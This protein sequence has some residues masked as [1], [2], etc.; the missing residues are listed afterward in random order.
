VIPRNSQEPEADEQTTFPVVSLKLSVVIVNWNTA[1]LLRE[2]LKSLHLETFAARGYEAIVVDN[3]SSDGSTAMVEHEFP[4]ARLIRM[5][6]NGG[7]SKGN[8][9]G[10]RQSRG[11]F[12]LLLNSDTEVQGN[13]LELM[14]SR[15]KA[16]PK[17]GALGAQLRNPDGTVQLSCRR[18][19]SYKTALFNRK[20][21]LTRLF[22]RNRFSQAYLMTHE[23]H[24]QT[25]EVDWVI[26]A[27]LMTRRAVLEQVGL[28]DEHFFMYAEDVDWCFRMRLRGWSVV[29]FPEAVVMHHY[30]RSTTKVPFK[31]NYQRHRSMWKFY[32]K[33]YSRGI[34]LMDVAT[35]LGIA[36][37][38]GAIAV[39]AGVH[40]LASAARKP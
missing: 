2:C 26:G 28:L 30:E 12:V 32:M 13:A 27:C 38:C 24:E 39:R 40:E 33:H 5:N 3:A 21:A 20:S 23:G 35:F 18:F 22:P 4:L 10:I 14:C 25:R 17:I 9:A 8:N 34:V 6:T 15:M 7:F 36:A 31:M 16:D 29:Y 11:E 37:R 19:P 1:E